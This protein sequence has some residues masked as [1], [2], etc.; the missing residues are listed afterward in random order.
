MDEA[1]RR[2]YNALLGEALIRLRRMRRDPQWQAA[3]AIPRMHKQERNAAFAH[4]RH[5]YSFSNY[6][7][8]A[9]AKQANGTWLAEHLDMVTAQTLAT[10]A[11][12]AVNRACLG[13][14]RRVR[15]KSRG[16]G[17][18]S[19][20]GKRNGTGLRFVLQ[21]PA[22]GSTGWFVWGKLHITVRVLGFAPQGCL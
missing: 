3:R 18:S 19:L 8:Q 12:R 2:L 5:A 20:E 17:I 14:A 16:R 11:Y 22:E 13:Q 7:L 15:F 21:P 4:L 10:R 9:F 1:A 6:A